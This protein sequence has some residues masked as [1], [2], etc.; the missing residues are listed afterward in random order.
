MK[1]TVSGRAEKTFMKL[2]VDAKTDKAREERRAAPIIDPS[3]AET[4]ALLYC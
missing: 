3:A 4:V 2:I 1:N